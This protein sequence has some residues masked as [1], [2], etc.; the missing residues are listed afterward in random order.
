MFFPSQFLPDPLHTPTHPI[1]VVSFSK[2]K[3]KET[4]KK[5][6]NNPTKM[7][8]KMNNECL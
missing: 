8:I 7:K 1:L 5:L 3:I 2:T 6:Q 4:N